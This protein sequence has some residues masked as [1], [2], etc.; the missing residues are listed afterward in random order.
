[1]RNDGYIQILTANIDGSGRRTFIKRYDF[2]SN[3]LDIVDRLKGK[4]TRVV[5]RVTENKITLILHDI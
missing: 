5:N 1:M 3:P 4:E 2:I